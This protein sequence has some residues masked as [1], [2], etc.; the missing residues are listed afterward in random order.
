M[1][2]SALSG[3]IALAKL[4]ALRPV[5]ETYGHRLTSCPHMHQIIPAVLEKEKSKLKE[6]L[7]DVK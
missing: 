2:V 7:K 1:V 5:L 4:D 3:G 6:E